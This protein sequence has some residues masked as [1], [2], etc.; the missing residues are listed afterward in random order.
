MNAF[1]PLDVFK[2]DLKEFG[3]Y[4]KQTPPAKGFTEVL[5]PGEIEHKN[6]QQRR[7]DGIYIEDDTWSEI[8]EL[9][10]QHKLEQVIG[11]P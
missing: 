3:E 6:E 11:Q 5:Y 8:W 7:R 10:E 2:K 9:V 1:R 4:V